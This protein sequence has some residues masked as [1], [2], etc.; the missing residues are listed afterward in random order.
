MR[1][2]H[3]FNLLSF[4][5]L[6]FAIS[7]CTAL[8]EPELKPPYPEK[9]RNSNLNNANP[10]STV[11]NTDAWWLV[12]NDAVLNETVALAQKQNLS[13]AQTSERLIAARNIGASIIAGQHAQVGFTAGPDNLARATFNA[14]GESGSA[15]SR[16][17]RTKGAYLAGFDLNW[18]LPLF[19]RQEA[20]RKIANAD[21]NHAYASIQAISVSTTA[22]VVRTYFN[23]RAAQEKKQ[24]LSTQLAN[25]E[26]LATLHAGAVASGLVSKNEYEHYRASVAEAKHALIHAKTQ[27]EVAIQRLS[28]L[29]G[30]IKPLDHWLEPQTT[31]QI[32]AL[33]TSH[34]NFNSTPPAE[35]IRQR[36]DIMQAEATVMN[37]AGQAGVA[38]ADIYPRLSIQGALQVAGSIGNTRKTQYI[39]VIA[40]ALRLPVV[41]WGL[42]RDVATARDAKLR[43]AILGYR[44]AVLLAV[45]ETETAFLNYNAAQEHL[46]ITQIES[47][48]WAQQLT[49]SESAY[50]AGYIAKVDLLKAQ[51]KSIEYNLQAVESKLEWVTAFTLANKAQAK[52]RDDFYQQTKN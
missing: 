46:N 32:N 42:A 6:C 34:V 24:L 49:R 22:E 21:I 29:C 48:H 20:E 2:T 50:Q 13:I 26:S 16:N 23:L 47:E 39:N 35:L 51:T 14:S 17:F 9:W 27:Q 5:L 12:L 38:H 11:S 15:S 28:V 10:N 25:L 37:A 40:P 18:E 31:Q 44:E 7:A 33:Q 52:M 30:V 1:L 3:Y 43:E 36:P 4:A 45:E 19:G 8:K 41:D